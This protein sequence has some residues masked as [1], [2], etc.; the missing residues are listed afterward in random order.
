M[1]DPLS[2]PVA[3]SASPS[4]P[5]R[6]V[7]L[8]EKSFAPT[9]TVNPFVHSESNYTFY[10]K[11]KTVLLFPLAVI[12]ILVC[13][14]LCLSAALWCRL[15]LVGFPPPAPDCSD[16]EMSWLRRKTINVT[17]R[18]H[19]RMFL[20]VM[21]FYWIPITGRPDPQC[22]LMLANHTTMVDVVVLL[23]ACAPSFLSKASVLQAPLI[24]SVCRAMQVIGVDRFN[25]KDK[26]K[27]KTKMANYLAHTSPHHPAL[28]VFPEGTTSRYDT[29]M[30]FKPGAF[31]F[32]LPIQ[33]VL[34]H[35]RFR[36]YDPS[37][38]ATTNVGAW[39][40]G[41]M[42]QFVHHVEVEYLPVLVPQPEE[43]AN[44]LFFAHNAQK[45]VLHSLQR[46]AN[47]KPWVCIDN[48]FQHEVYSVSCNVDD[49]LVWKWFLRASI[50][51]IK[52]TLLTYSLESIRDVIGLVTPLLAGKVD[53]T[54][55]LQ[56]AERYSRVWHNQLD[57]QHVNKSLVSHSELMACVL[58]P[59]ASAACRDVFI[60][61][62][63]EACLFQTNIPSN[64][65]FPGVEFTADKCDFRQFATAL[66]WLSHT[67][68]VWGSRYQVLDEPQ[69]SDAGVLK[70]ISCRAKIVFAYICSHQPA[71]EDIS[72][73]DI[74]QFWKQDGL[75][76]W[77][78]VF[79]DVQLEQ[80]QQHADGEGEDEF[81]MSTAMPAG[82]TA[83]EFREEIVNGVLQTPT[84][85]KGAERDAQLAKQVAC[86]D[87]LAFFFARI[88]EHFKQA[89]YSGGSFFLRDGDMTHRRVSE[90]DVQA[91]ESGGIQLEEEAG[92]SKALITQEEQV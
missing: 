74:V 19:C 60:S 80:Q 91:D 14:F 88:D 20:F 27:T 3:E 23:Y 68:L 43:Q 39:L 51:D 5:S 82:L 81:T 8:R 52:Y 2:S 50:P 64:A 13:V 59:L 25:P 31:D 17:V 40:L 29:V 72:R 54:I 67:S 38:T 77:D 83:T 75:A 26:L 63:S 85:E 6:L 70:W 16:P 49:F 34:L 37:S 44:A 92:D 57:H 10:S 56:V 48:G 62:F 33:P 1:A 9:I 18:A 78:A 73:V 61:A 36:H 87:L 24:G 69:R 58:K 47:A 84:S 4:R 89:H 55:I 15:L 71:R 11:I 41:M 7:L 22:K 45:I 90:N 35:W 30:R 21:G 53:L 28:M 86:I 42:T 46:R 32:G 76:L 66:V 65:T 12:R 79:T